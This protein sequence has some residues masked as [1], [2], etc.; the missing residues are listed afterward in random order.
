MNHHACCITH[1][2]VL[3]E[4]NEYNSRDRQILSDRVIFVVML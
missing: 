1:C 4:L 2:R 3:N